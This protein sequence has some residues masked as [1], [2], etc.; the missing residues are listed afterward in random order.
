MTV[1]T[2]KDNLNNPK[3]LMDLMFKE[4]SNQMEL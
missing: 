4:E 1:M 2:L 3:D